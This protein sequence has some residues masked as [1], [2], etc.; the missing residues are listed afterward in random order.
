MDDHYEQDPHYRVFLRPFAA[1]KGTLLENLDPFEGY[2]VKCYWDVRM[3]SSAAQENVKLAS[4]LR[5]RHTNGSMDIN[6]PGDIYGRQK[7]W[8]ETGNIELGEDLA[9]REKW[10]S[11]VN[12]LEH[13]GSENGLV[14]FTMFPRKQYENEDAQF[15]T[16]NYGAVEVRFFDNLAFG[17]GADMED[18]MYRF[19]VKCQVDIMK[20]QYDQ[21]TKMIRT[22]GDIERIHSIT[23]YYPID[24]L[25]NDSGLDFNDARNHPELFDFNKKISTNWPQWVMYNASGY[26]PANLVD[27][28][29]FKF[30]NRLMN[31]EVNYK[32]YNLSP[33]TQTLRLELDPSTQLYNQYYEAKNHLNFTEGFHGAL[34]FE[35]DAGPFGKAGRYIRNQVM[36]LNAYGNVDINGWDG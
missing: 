17:T 35:V 7:S 19:I 33:L 14:A 11:K 21:N 28:L 3:P 31:E 25:L 29:F 10:S 5:F 16:E 32:A 1:K 34:T 20:G 13:D 8:Y 9:I 22:E 18:M 15:A 36:Y 26:D 6:N 12:K 27:P 2:F 4:F 30:G 24:I 23:S